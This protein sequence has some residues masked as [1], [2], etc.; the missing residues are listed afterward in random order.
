MNFPDYDDSTAFLGDWGPFQ[1]TVFILLCLSIIPNGFT[2]LSIVFLGDTP[3]HRC[4]IPAAMNIT[5]EWR[6]A[7]IPLDEDDENNFQFSKCS[8]HRMDIVKN[9][10]D[11]GLL[12]WVDVNVSTIPQEGCMDGW[13][14]DKGT[15][16]S[17][18]VSEWDL[19]CSDDWR[20]PL[21]SSLFYS[22]VLTGSLISG[23][24][25][26]RFGR[27][28]VL[29][30]TMAIQTVFTSIKI[31]SILGCFRWLPILARL[32]NAATGSYHP[33]FLLHTPLVVVLIACPN[34]T[35]SS[36]APSLS[37][38]QNHRSSPSP[39]VPSSPL[40]SLL[41]P[42]S[43]SGSPLVISGPE[44]VSVHESVPENAPVPKSG[45]EW[46]PVSKPSPAQS[47]LLFPSLA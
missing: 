5:D 39:L 15:Y 36:K 40:S 41:I 43:P 35:E 20:A 18:I 29:F 1:R 6:N 4:L 44:R 34:A 9:Y 33:W 46:S 14:Y 22:G 10:S 23:Q 26:D 11:R 17:T 42:S 21:T 47:R 28:N 19:V 3:A 24:M 32:E 45:P 27:K 38:A 25:S 8:R 16:I 30:V 12:P 13:E 31:S 37:S 2:G 7:S